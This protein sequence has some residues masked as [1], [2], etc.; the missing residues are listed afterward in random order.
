MTEVRIE[1]L[2]ISRGPRTVV[3]NVTLAFNPG[4]LV[5]LIGPN[6]AGKTTLMRA[7]LGLLPHTGTSTLAAL[8]PRERARIAAWL[9]QT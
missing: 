9:P 1:N 8:P 7:A 5:G 4:Q 2:S 6:G 3:Q